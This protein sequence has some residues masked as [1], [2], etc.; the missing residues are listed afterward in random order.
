MFEKSFIFSA[1]TDAEGRFRSTQR[2]SSPFSLEVKITATPQ[3]PSGVTI[4]AAFDL[5]P[6]DGPH[7]QPVQFSTPSGEAA[8]LGK[9][10]V[11][12]GDDANVATATG[13]TEPPAADSEVT[14]EF[15]ATPSFS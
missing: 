7:T 10:K 11:A 13:Y 12:A 6:V 4:H 9:W 5:A 3:S 14:V 8:D 1:M 15:V 2:V